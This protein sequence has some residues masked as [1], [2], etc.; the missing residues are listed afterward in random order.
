MKDLK[1]TTFLVADMEVQRD[2]ALHGPRPECPAWAD[3]KHCYEWIYKDPI[4]KVCA[5]GSKVG[6]AGD[7]AVRG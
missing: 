7:E 2:L 4:R 3:G 6:P 1:D 5:C